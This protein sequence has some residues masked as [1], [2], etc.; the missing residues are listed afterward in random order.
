MLVMDS[1]EAAVNLYSILLAFRQSEGSDLI[2][3]EN[4]KYIT[5]WLKVISEQVPGVRDL[6]DDNRGPLRGRDLSPIDAI[7]EL[8]PKER[9]LMLTICKIIHGQLTTPNGR[10]NWIENQGRADYELAVKNFQTWVNSLEGEG[11]SA[12]Q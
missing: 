5:K 7:L 6:A 4:A 11:M 3:R 12:G 8:D 10:R 9:T 2:D 1:K